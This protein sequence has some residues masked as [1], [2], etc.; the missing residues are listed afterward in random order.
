MPRNNHYT[1]LAGDSHGP[2]VQPVQAGVLLVNLGTPTAPTAKAVRPYL[3]EFLGDPRVIEYPRW[4]WW[5]ILHGVI[6]RVR[7]ARSAHAY[8]RI[9]TS[10]GSPLRFGS[11]A[12]AAGLQAELDRQQP[13][14]LRVALAMRYGEPS[15]AHTI[16]QLQREGVRRLLVLPLYPQYSATSTGSVIDAVADTLK[17]LRWPPELRLVN[18]YHDDPGHIEALAQSIER[19][20]QTNGRGDKLLLSFHGIPE[21]YVQLG[22]P[23]FRQCHRHRAMPARTTAA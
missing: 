8:A 14:T 12:L 9:W 23:Y 17:T 20:W 11:E 16:E 18:D 19:W 3:A 7:P 21:R 13:G 2:P 10:A 5:L 1:G 15:V 22:D 6:L 4:L